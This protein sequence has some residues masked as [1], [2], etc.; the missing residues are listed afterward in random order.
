MSEETHKKPQRRRKPQPIVFST[1][2]HSRQEIIEKAGIYKDRPNTVPPREEDEK[3]EFSDMTDYC[4]FEADGIPIHVEAKELDHRKKPK[5]LGS[6]QYGQ[7]FCYSAKFPNGPNQH[8]KF[9]FAAKRIPIHRGA[10]DANRNNELTLRDRRVALA[11]KDCEFTVTY[12][13]SMIYNAQVWIIMELMDA[14]LHE[15]YKLA[16][17]AYKEKVISNLIGEEEMEV[18]SDFISEVTNDQVMPEDFIKLTVYS[19]V[20]AL[21]YLKKIN[22]IHRDVKPSNILI[23]QK[24]QIKLC[25]FGISGELSNSLVKSH[26]GCQP[27]MAPERIDPKSPEPELF[28]SESFT[29]ENKS[30]AYGVRSDVWSLGITLTEIANGAYPFDNTNAQGKM[31]TRFEQISTIIT[32]K[33]KKVSG[34]YTIDMVE[35]IEACLLPLAKRFSFLKKYE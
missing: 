29:T 15:F 9:Q 18:D 24:T 33:P 28:L 7:V 26:V 27:Y 30:N 31:K 34:N 1:E 21:Q 11:S 2:T 10:D 16:H 22:V 32:E 20:S 13:G 23:N 17:G 8:A 35:F 19:I 6:G 25:D 14:N 4:T 12:Y 5:L 3:K